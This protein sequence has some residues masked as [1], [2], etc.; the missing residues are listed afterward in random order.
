[1]SLA[2]QQSRDNGPRKLLSQNRRRHRRANLVIKGRFLNEKSED[3]ELV[4]Q[5]MSC[6]GALFTS[7]SIPRIDSRIVCYIGHIGRVSAIVVRHSEDG[8]AVRFQTTQ[9]KRDKLADKLTWLLNREPLNL[10]EQRAAPR[11]AARGPALIRRENG[12]RLQCRVIDISLTGA[13]FKT[14]GA[15]PLIG[16]IVTAGNL[17]GKVV[18]C[19]E[20]F[21]AIAYLTKSDAA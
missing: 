11:Y 4:T 6:G 17:K 19:E 2:V 10:E 16:E 3:H 13:G 18:R 1:M 8:F 21:F 15:A 5:N 20:D 9:L 12:Q 7:E 14:D